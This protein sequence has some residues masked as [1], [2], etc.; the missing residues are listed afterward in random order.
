MPENSEIEETEKDVSLG[1][2]GR[3]SLH[4]IYEH[5]WI[6]VRRSTP[7]FFTINNYKHRQTGPNWG[8]LWIGSNEWE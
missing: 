5:E 7:N 4:T 1:N 8:E 3:A 6:I 2:L